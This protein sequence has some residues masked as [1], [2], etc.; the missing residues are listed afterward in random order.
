MHVTILT[1]TRYVFGL[2]FMM[3][4][5]YADDASDVTAAERQHQWLSSLANPLRLNRTA[6]ITVSIVYFVSAS[7]ASEQTDTQGQR[8]VCRE[9]YVETKLCI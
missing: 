6:A 7:Y 5:G 4:N 3:F 9:L 1:S 2:C 8:D